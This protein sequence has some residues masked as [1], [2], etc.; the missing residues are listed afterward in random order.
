MLFFCLCFFSIEIS[1]A[2]EEALK[3]KFSLKD[4][5]FTG[6]NMGLQIGNPTMIDISPLIGF[7]ITKHA[8]AGFGV[9]YLYYKYNDNY[10]GSVYISNIYGGRIFAQHTIWKNIFAHA[11]YEVLNGEWLQG[12]RYNITSV[13]I[14][15]GFRQALFGRAYLNLTIL[16]NLN[17]TYDSP[18]TNPIIRAGISIG[19]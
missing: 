17:N 15:A 3:Q 1:L 6:G 5:I 14:G 18:Y 4:R 13:L 12:S 8:S 19:L 16:W 7:K 10:Y 11:E 9:T 2:Q